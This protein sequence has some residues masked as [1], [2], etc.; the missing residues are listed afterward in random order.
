[1]RLCGFDAQDLGVDVPSDKIIG[2]AIEINTDVLAMSALLTTTRVK[3]REG[4]EALE[5]EGLRK[6]FKIMVGGAP[7]M[8]DWVKTIG[9]HGYSQDAIEAVH[10]AKL[11]LGVTQ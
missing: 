2:K 5:K 6:R 11:M 7:V 4:I 10:P 1:M 8:T 9:A 3:Q